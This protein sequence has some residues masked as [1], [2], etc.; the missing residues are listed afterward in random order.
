MATK[1]AEQTLF[2]RKASGLVKGWSGGDGFRYS[3]FSTNI[4]LG[5]WGFLYAVFI[6]GGSV[7]WS[8]IITT[9]FVLLE[10]VVYAG[11]I[12]AMP[13]AG[14]D[15]VWQS[16]VFHS[17]VGFVFGATGWWF[18]LW[19]WIPIY[20]ALC[21][22]SFIK[23]ILRILG[24]NGAA[25]WLTSQW[26]IFVAS[27]ATIA[28]ATYLV[29]VG[30][31]AYANFQKWALWIGLAGLAVGAILLIVTSKASFIA[32]FNREMF[33]QFGV[34]EAYSAT[35]KGAG[36]GMPSSMFAGTLKDTFKLI[37]VMAFWLLWPV[38][39]ATLYGEVRG[40][41]DF[42]KNIYQMGGG[43]LAAV[44][45]VLVFLGL[46]TKTMGWNFFEASANGYMGVLYAY[47]DPAAVPGAGEYLSPTAMTAWIVNNSAFQVIFIA[48]I[49]LIV[50]GWWGTVFLS[51]TRMIFAS[52]FDRILP[53]SVAKVTSGGVP[54]N[55]LLLMAIP[56]VIVSAFYAFSPTFVQLT[57]DATL[58]IAAMFFVTGP[59][60]RVHAAPR[61]G[62]LAELG[63][64]QGPD[65][66]DHRRHLRDLHG[67]QPLPV[68][69]RQDQR[70]RRRLQEQE[71]HDLHGDPLRGRHRD[72]DHRLGDPQASGHGAR[73]SRQGDSSRVTHE[74]PDRDEAVRPEG[75]LPSRGHEV[76]RRATVGTRGS[77]TR[78]LRKRQTRRSGAGGGR[79][80]AAGALARRTSRADKQVTPGRPGTHDQRHSGGP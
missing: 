24:A 77:A 52:A 6:P 2:V 56:S 41:K 73:S 32:A 65:P 51:S 45:I 47:I 79:R 21:V 17:S 80:T 28:L 8:I 11:L 3:F 60:V 38:W 27:L 35:I 33:S 12:S 57:Y 75:E 67:L 78:D 13:R 14:G 70:L 40:A 68:V 76:H 64:A 15:Y 53:E 39:G 62:D 37:P 43:L 72:L 23:P 26:G 9:I 16:R 66:P 34:R 4:F 1:P 71:L 36:E 69:L 48:A 61:Q 19:L 10:V 55:A 25:D 29:A 49:S 74:R 22:N 63:A 44:A 50:F 20:A 54:V 5:I 42:R 7:F 18:I 30:M 59:R 31:K 46:V 58:V